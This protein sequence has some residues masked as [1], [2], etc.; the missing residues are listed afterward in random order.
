MSHAALPAAAWLLKV[1]EDEA[2]Q[3]E[4]ILWVDIDTVILDA[5]FTLP[6]D[7]LAARSKDLVV[8]GNL[9][10]VQAGHPVKGDLFRSLYAQ[11]KNKSFT[12]WQNAPS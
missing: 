8:Y 3:G 5:N 7:D 2:R 9:T 1:L 6:Y 12:V 11:S 10:Q 4:W